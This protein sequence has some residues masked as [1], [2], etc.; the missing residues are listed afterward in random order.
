MNND[1]K[2]Q[3]RT[4]VTE[5]AP[6]S[7]DSQRIIPLADFLVQ[8]LEK[9]YPQN[10]SAYL[11]TGT[12]KPTE[13]RSYSN[14]FKRVLRDANADN[15]NFHA[16]RHTFATRCIESGMDIKSLSK[17]LGHSSV[18]ITLDRYVHP[19]AALMKDGI[20]KMAESR[21]KM[22]SEKQSK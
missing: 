17:I 22:W 21:Q 11:L 10:N 2:Q 12:E 4:R 14:F 15:Y 20:N 7:E 16:L 5:T 3:Q 19:S 6:K 18:K 9:I 13:P 1:S 8:I